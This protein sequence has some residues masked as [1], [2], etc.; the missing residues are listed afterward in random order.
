MHHL[1]KGP[2]GKDRNGTKELAPKHPEWGLNTN[3]E[4]VEYLVSSALI[5]GFIDPL[6]IRAVAGA[7]GCQ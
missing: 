6:H 7:C 2:I 1:K 5:A 4:A 3:P